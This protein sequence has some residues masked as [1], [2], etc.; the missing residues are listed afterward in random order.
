MCAVAR[1]WDHRSANENRRMQDQ[2]LRQT[3][4]QMYYGHVP[5]AKARLDAAG[6]ETRRFKGVEE[7]A[8]LPTATRVEVLDPVRNPAGARGMI[9]EG[10]SE[11]VRRFSDRSVL[12]R[13]AK[14]RLFGGEEVQQL[15]IEAASRPIH[16]NLAQGPGGPIPVA[17]T[18][19]DLDLFARGGARM[20]KLVG[21]E[22]TDRLL[23]LVPFGPTLDFWGVFYMA[24]GVGMSPI[25]SRP[26]GG[27]LNRALW[28]FESTRPTAVAVPADEAVSFGRA[29]RDAG[30]DLTEL[31]ALVAVGRSLTVNER[32]QIGEE[33]AAS[34]AGNARIAAA[35]GIAEG[36]TLWAECAVPAGKTQT[37]GFHTSPDL[38]IVE[39]LSPET[40][41]PLGEQTPGEITVTPLGFHGGGVPR[42]RSGDLA[43]GGVTTE[44][45][46]NCGRSVP[47]VGPSV[48]KGAWQRRV[49][50]DGRLV[51][52]DFRFAAVSTAPRAAQWQVELV[53]DEQAGQLFVYLRPRSDDPTPLIELYEELERWGTPPT[54][55][56]LGSDAELEGRISQTEGVFR[57]FAER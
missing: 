14:A 31:S 51:R 17:Y 18:R 1:P 9:L 45:C 25:H 34:G 47:R 26:E 39:V 57:R 20:S 55:I 36:R 13:V 32:E 7:L 44:P 49:R 38:E 21:I 54:Q 12:Y 41:E 56:V 16:V 15:A 42:W 53:G 28:A 30:L 40:G 24:H 46:P 52:F 27:D 37:F 11:G 4:L 33:L 48:R 10:T 50:L 2:L 6:V 5:T 23:N 22:R 3:L 35:Y 43:L 29:A 8:S 19:D